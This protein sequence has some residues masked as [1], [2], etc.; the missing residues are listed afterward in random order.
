[1][2]SCEFASNAPSSITMRAHLAGALLVSSSRYGNDKVLFGRN[3]SVTELE[4]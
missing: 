4:V 3:I 2:Y 1:M